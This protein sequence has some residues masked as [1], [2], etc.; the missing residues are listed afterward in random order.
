VDENAEKD[1]RRAVHEHFQPERSVPSFLITQEGNVV[2][3]IIR[4]AKANQVD[5]VRMGRKSAE[6]APGAVAE[7]IARKTF[8]ST[9]FVPENWSP[10]IQHIS[11]PVDFSLHSEM[12]LQCAHVLSQGL[13]ASVSCLHV[14][15]VPS[16]YTKTGKSF[17]EFSSLMQQHIHQEFRSFLRWVFPEEEMPEIPLHVACAEGIKK[18]QLIHDMAQE[19]HT[20]LMLVGS[21]GRS[22]SSGVL[23]GSVAE[24]L[25]RRNRH[26]PLLMIKNKGENMNLLEALLNL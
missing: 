4:H 9:V 24:G 15:E 26:Y 14:Y 13:G 5:L 17:E 2:E 23:I 20:D 12:A 18:T 16:G 21:K 10:T 19:R 1:L 3:Q 11:V 8:C 7:R 22:A 25:I 6:G